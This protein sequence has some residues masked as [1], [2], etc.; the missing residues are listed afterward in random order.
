[1]AGDDPRAL[2]VVRDHPDRE[3]VAPTQQAGQLLARVVLQH[4]LDLA[5]A[6]EIEHDDLVAVLR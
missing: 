1:V 5:R 2:R 3:G 4:V 6:V